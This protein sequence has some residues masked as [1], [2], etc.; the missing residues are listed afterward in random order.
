MGCWNETC[1]LTDLPIISGEKICAV[2]IEHM[3][4]DATSCYPSENWCPIGPAIWGTYNGYGSLEDV[5]NGKELKKQMHRVM[6]D[7]HS[8]FINQDMTPYRVPS[9]DELTSALREVEISCLR[10]GSIHRLQVV[11][12][13]EKSIETAKQNPELKA[14]VG[15]ESLTEKSPVFGTFG[16]RSKLLKDFAKN[17]A[18]LSDIVAID[19]AY[20]ALRRSWHPTSGCGSQR[21]IESKWTAEWYQMVADEAHCAHQ[22]YLRSSDS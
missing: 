1:A 3:R 19:F 2:I 22:E 6:E 16:M 5:R 17:E 20:R 7:T 11:F 18:D 13:K 15:T 4:Q 9:M 8:T 12:F 14:F 10:E 21:E